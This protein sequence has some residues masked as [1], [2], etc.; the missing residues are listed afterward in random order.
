MLKKTD[1]PQ[2]RWIVVISA[3]FCA[4]HSSSDLL[5]LIC[6]DVSH[7]QS[8][9]CLS[10]SGIFNCVKECKREQQLCHHVKIGILESGYWKNGD[11]GMNLKPITPIFPSQPREN[12]Q[13]YDGSKLSILLAVVFSIVCGWPLALLYF[14]ARLEIE[15]AE[16]RK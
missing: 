8:I 12:P 16:R 11:G 2:R 14:R 5:F 10:E 15:A 3:P 4:S 6:D 9:V 7:R 13:I 1:K